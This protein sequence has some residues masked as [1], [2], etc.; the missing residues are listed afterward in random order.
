MSLMHQTGLRATRVLSPRNL[1]SS[2][3]RQSVGAPRP[4]A[5]SRTSV[6]TMATEQPKGTQRPLGA[7]AQRTEQKTWKEMTTPEKGVFFFNRYVQESLPN[8]R[9][10]WDSS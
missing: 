1:L 2:G 8:G 4:A 3:L 6:R 9:T 7:L 5:L 10:Y